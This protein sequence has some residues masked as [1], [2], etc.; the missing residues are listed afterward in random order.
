MKPNDHFS[1][2]S[3]NQVSQDMSGLTRYYLP[4]VGKDAVALYL[5]LVSFWD[6]G[7][8]Q[9]LFSHILNH[10]DF[11]MEVLERSLE[12]LS[13]IGLLELF[14]T[15]TGFFIR[16]Y[17]TLSAEDFFAHHVYSSLL[18][19]KIGQAAVDKLRPENPAG[20]KIGAS[21]SQI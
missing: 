12:R 11:G 16:L 4:I 3:N 2:L 13:A 7:T 5:Y 20:Q 19:K 8:Q 15:E 10:L 21:F 6:N 17:P 18:E 9:R 14:Q 1:F